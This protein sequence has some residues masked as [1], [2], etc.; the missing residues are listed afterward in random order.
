MLKTVR[1]LEN[2]GLRLKKQCEYLEICLLIAGDKK[3]SLKITAQQNKRKI[4]EDQ[5]LIHII[6]SV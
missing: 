1:T 2:Q 4:T 5:Q 3:I 6:N